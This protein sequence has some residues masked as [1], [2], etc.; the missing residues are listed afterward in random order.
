[1]AL[2]PGASRRVLAAPGDLRL[3]YLAQRPS[4]V[5]H[6]TFV[7]Q[8]RAHGRALV[9]ELDDAVSAY[10][11]SETILFSAKTPGELPE[12]SGDFDGVGALRFSPTSGSEA[13]ARALRLLSGD[14]WGSA[15]PESLVLAR[16]H[17]MHEDGGTKIQLVGFVSRKP[18]LSQSEFSAYWRDHHGPIFLSVEDVACHVR[19]YVQNHVWG[20][21]QPPELPAIYDGVVEDGFASVDDLG[22]FY[23]AA[24]WEAISPDEQRFLNFD[25][26]IVVA[27]QCPYR[28][29]RTGAA[30]VGSA[31]R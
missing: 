5:D 15:V 9:E 21:P 25:Q 26:M 7:D 17:V 29:A 22:V 2:N 20:T 10:E 8:W 27:T 18:S 30:A 11:L 31:A 14:S 1:M 4:D 6:Q 12:V 24:G 19:R 13:V 28:I 3:F 16:E 23:R